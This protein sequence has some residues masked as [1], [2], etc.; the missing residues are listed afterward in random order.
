MRVPNWYRVDCGSVRYHRSWNLQETGLVVHGFSAR[1]GG[2][3]AG[4]Y[5]SL[6]LGFGTEDAPANV[7]SNRAA[8]ASA[9]GLV[10]ETIVV[11][12]QVHSNN[13]ER[14]GIAHAGAGALERV[15]AISDTDALVTNEPG[16][17]LALHFADCVCIFLLDPVMRAIGVAHAGWR[18][19]VTRI[20]SATVERMVSEFGSNP[21]GIVA[22]IAPSV[23]RCCYEVG[24][25]VAHEFFREFPH[26][27]RVMNQASTE[28][29]RVDLKI[30]NRLLLMEAGL[31]PRNIAVSDECT[32]CNRTDFFSYR[33]DGETGRMSGWLSLLQ[34]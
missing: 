4:P 31:D 27:E 28:K 19:T 8:Y 16:V 2:V 3:S 33:R 10:P 9:L 6:N 23:G 15:T 32:C 24:P 18:G 34:Q 7:V 22:A 12:G 30:A 1:K 21:A 20:V 25:D 29:W 26:D 11:P 14:V 13:V 17:T 5:E